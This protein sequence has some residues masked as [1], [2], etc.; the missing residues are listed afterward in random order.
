[1][2]IGSVFEFY[3]CFSYAIS[4][5]AVMIAKPRTASAVHHHEAQDSIIYAIRGHGAVVFDNGKRKELLNPG[6]FAIIP[7]FVE[8]QEVNEGDDE[9]EWSVHSQARFLGRLS[10]DA[11]VKP[12]GYVEAGIKS[13]KFAPLQDHHPKWTITKSDQ[14]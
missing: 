6:D 10:Q 12:S 1:M 11:R 4:Y 8:H 7:A 13:A 14:S 9:V 2:C 3:S 5:I